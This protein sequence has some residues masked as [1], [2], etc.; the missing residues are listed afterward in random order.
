VRPR[1]A[2]LAFGAHRSELAA[3]ASDHL[4]V[5][6]VIATRAIASEALPKPR[7]ALRAVG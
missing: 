6:A 5:K 4:P 7:A 3:L 2:L 1:H